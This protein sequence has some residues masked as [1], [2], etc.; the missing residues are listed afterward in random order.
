MNFIQ[1]KG[2]VLNNLHLKNLLDELRRELIKQPKPTIGELMLILSHRILEDSIIEH[3]VMMQTIFDFE[4]IELIKYFPI[5]W[6]IIIED[7]TDLCISEY[8]RMEDSEIQEFLNILKQSCKKCYDEYIS[9]GCN[10][11][12]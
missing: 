10:Y 7:Y 8:V 9:G 11:V 12:I 3:R 6:V 4:D 1:A 5:I 2:Q